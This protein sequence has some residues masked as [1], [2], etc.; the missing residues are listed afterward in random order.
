MLS[1]MFRL[2]A[3]VVIAIARS[4]RSAGKASP[5]PDSARPQAALRNPPLSVVIPEH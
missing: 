3:G 1:T 5:K 4:P 2:L